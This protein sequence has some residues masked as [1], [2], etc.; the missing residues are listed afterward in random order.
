DTQKNQIVPARKDAENRKGAGG[1]SPMVKLMTISV[2]VPTAAIR[3]PS[4]H[5]SEQAKPNTIKR[6]GISHIAWWSVITVAELA[7]KNSGVH[8]NAV[9]V[10]SALLPGASVNEES[11]VPTAKATAMFSSAA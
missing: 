7:T 10:L 6:M 8:H 11:S 1:F 2:S 9:C 3:L 5:S 4:A